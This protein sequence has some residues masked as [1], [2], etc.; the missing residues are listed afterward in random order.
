MKETLRRWSKKSSFKWVLAFLLAWFLFNELIIF[1]INAYFKAMLQVESV[2]Q[3]LVLFIN[4]LGAI[5]FSI[6]IF[7][8]NG[9]EDVKRKAV[10]HRI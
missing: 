8:I 7:R 5:I 2:N 6:L 4:I 1:Y 3:D 9:T 10:K